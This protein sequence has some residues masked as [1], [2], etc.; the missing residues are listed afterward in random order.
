MQIY[1]ITNLINGKIYI[2]KD[3]VS[4]KNYYGSGLLIKR[5]INKHG[6][7]NFKKEILEECDNNDELCVRE[8]YWIEKYNSTNSQIGYNISK[9]G[10]GGDTISNN[11]NKEEIRLKISNI[12]KGKK[13]EDLFPMEKVI[14][15]KE[16]LSNKS[17][18]RLKG[19][20]YEELHGV[21]KAKEIKEKQ[22][23]TRIELNSKIP[24]KIKIK[25]TDEEIKERRIIRLKEK[26]KN[27][28]DI[29]ILKK[30]YHQFNRHNSLEL[31][32]QLI[33]IE[34]YNL[35]LSELKKPFKHSIESILLIKN[36]KKNKFLEEKNK[37]IKFLLDNPDK[38]RNDYYNS[39]TKSQ[40]S[41]KVRILTNGKSS[42]LLSEEEK[43]LIKKRPKRK[44][45]W[46][47]DKKLLLKT[48]LGRKIVIDDIEYISAS[49]ASKILGVDRGT[50][51]FRMKS[52]NYP[53]YKYL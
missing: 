42:N 3:T 29:E 32:I 50:I 10:D 48:K 43:E 45:N 38:T 6:I 5:S 13:Y 9:G 18:E 17:R 41:T 40:I 35:V 7:E 34:M 19:K 51:R 47:E 53:N 8:K 36:N 25:L 21:E 23:K 49:E 24:K 39:L 16:R 26:Y 12:R 14:Q 20:T 15:Y 22:S 44:N 33:G 1:K 27:I 31:F 52:N 28:T 37:L 4:D 46:S 2:G 30:S 11:P